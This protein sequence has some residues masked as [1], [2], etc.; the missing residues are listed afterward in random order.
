M[1]FTTKYSQGTQRRHYLAQ[2]TSASLPPRKHRSAPLAQ[3]HSGNVSTRSQ[4][5]K[6]LIS[7]AS[8]IFHHPIHV[9]VTLC[10][11]GFGAL[12]RKFN[13][14]PTQPEFWPTV[15]SVLLHYQFFSPQLRCPVNQRKQA[16]CRRGSS[17]SVLVHF[18]SPTHQDPGEQ[19]RCCN[20]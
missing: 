13:H 11:Y 18:H 1:S 2:D 9:L 12:R 7:S 17:Q 6:P 5:A 8:P 15:S 10:H 3:H 19:V 14:K 4:A 20:R 16:A